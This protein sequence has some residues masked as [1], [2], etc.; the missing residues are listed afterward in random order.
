MVFERKKKSE[1][2]DADLVGIWLSLFR[3]YL[4]FASD[5]IKLFH[6][7]THPS[8]FQKTDMHSAAMTKGLT[9]A[10]LQTLNAERESFTYEQRCAARV[11]QVR[12]GGWY[13][14]HS[15]RK[16]KKGRKYIENVEMF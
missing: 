12:A 10:A 14:I 9:T 7:C 16:V 3:L 2:D 15:E 1:L 6:N 8:I 5:P 4:H 11:I 13:S